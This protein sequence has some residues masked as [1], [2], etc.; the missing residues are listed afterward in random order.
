MIYFPYFLDSGSV[1]RWVGSTYYSL[2]LI[3][4]S[5]RIRKIINFPVSSR[6]SSSKQN[7][8]FLLHHNGQIYQYSSVDF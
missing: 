8:R 6:L 5:P 2:L 7:N 3:I 4:P 1:L